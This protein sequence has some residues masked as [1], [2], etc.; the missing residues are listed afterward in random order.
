MKRFTAFILTFSILSLACQTL[1][2]PQFRSPT[3]SP[4][5]AISAPPQTQAP[6]IPSTPPTQ[7]PIMIS[8]MKEKLKELGGQPC[9]QKRAF[10]CVT[11]T[12]PLDHFDPANQETIDV[13]FAVAPARGERKGMYVQAYP[14]GPG[15]EGI[16][17]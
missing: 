7:T 5:R 14:G 11:I 12:V 6:T 9:K 8:D 3:T 1:T 10:T 13:V 4:T 16:S 2:N 17:S 15:G